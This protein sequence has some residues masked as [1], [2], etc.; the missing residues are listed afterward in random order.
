MNPLTGITEY[1][2]GLEK[3]LRLLAWT[4]GTAIFGAAAL[5]T[6][7]LLVLFIKQ[8]AFSDPSVFW[9]R[10]LLFLAVAAAI[11]AG[12]VVPLLRL[13][14]GRAARRAEQEFPQFQERLLTFTERAKTKADDP[15]L[16]LLA[17]DALN[18]AKTADSDAVAPRSWIVSFASAGVVALA[19]LLWLGMAGPGYLGYGTSLLWAGYA[20]D[21]R[22]PIYSIAVN[23]GNSTIRRRS[24]LRVTAKLTGFEAPKVNVM[25]RYASS[26][27]W[28]EAPMQ[29]RQDAPGYEFF[30]ASVPEPVEYYVEAGGVKSST[31]KINVSDLPGVKHVKVTYHFPSWSGIPDSTEDPGGDLRAVEGT[32]AQ[33]EITTDK[34]LS[35]GSLIVD[36]NN[37][38]ELKSGGGNT[39]VASVPINKDGLYHVAASDNGEM[40]RLSDDYFIEA[41]KD[42]PPTVTINRPGKDAKVNPIE[43]VTITA[44]GKDDFGV[45]ALDLHYSVN[46]GDEKV[47]SLLKNK[48]AKTTEGS[49]TVTL[50]DY[51]LV[52]GDL[53]SFYATAKDARTT[54]KTDIYF[55]QAEPFE[56]NYSQSQQGGG[57]GGGGDGN[58]Q[59]QISQ[60]QKE[61]IAATWNQLKSTNKATAAENAK[62]LSEVQ[63]KLKDQAQS[64]ADRMKARQLAGTN[65]AFTSFVKDMEAAVAAMTP[66]AG[67]LKGQ[68]WNTALPPEQ[69]ALQYLLRAEAT[70]RD[71]QV[72]FGQRGGGGGGGGGASRDLESLF[73]LELDKDKNQY[74]SSQQSQAEQRNKAVDDAMRKLEELARRQQA[75]ADQARNN[76]QTPQQRWQQ[77]MLRREAEQLRQQME[78]LQRDQQGQ[79]SQQSQQGQQGQQSASSSSSQ[80]S[81][82]SQ[83]GQSGQS[84]RMQQQSQLSRGQQGQQQQQQ[85]NQ[86][87]QQDNPVARRDTS[88][89]QAQQLEQALNRLAEAER[90]MAAASSAMQNGRQQQQQQQ[91]GQQGQQQGQQQAGQRGHQNGAQGQ[92]GGQQQGAGSQAQAQADARKAAEQ[93][94]AARDMLSRMREQENGDAMSNIVREAN[95]IAQQQEAFGH[96]MQQQ[97]GAGAPDPFANQGGFR[98]RRGPESV[99]DLPDLGT[100]NQ[101]QKQLADEHE[102]MANDVQ[103]LE[104]Q[105]QGA[106][107]DMMGTNRDAAN[108]LRQ[109]LGNEQQEEVPNKL[110][111]IAGMLNRGLGP[112]AVMREAP[113]TQALNNLRDQVQQVQSALNQGPGKGGKNG[114]D[115]ALEAA[116]Q[117]AEKLRQEIEALRGRQ[118]DPN[119]QQ[120]QQQGRNGQRGQQGQQGQQGQRGG[121]QPGQQ[122]QQGGQQQG[123]QAQGGQQ[124]GGQQQGGQQAGGQQGGQQQGGQQQGGQQE[125]GQQEGGQQMGGQMAGGPRGGN[126]GTRIGG[127]GG[128]FWDPQVARRSYEDAVRDVNRLQNAVRD[129]PDMLR[130]LRDIGNILP[131]LDPN[132]YPGGMGRDLERLFVQA[133]TNI[134]Q[135]EVQLRR[136]V[137]EQNGGAI[138]SATPQPPP[139]GYADAVADYFRRLSKDH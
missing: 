74:E 20:K 25:A 50:E 129:N 17:A 97:F 99:E 94:S 109:A 134:E 126:I 61:I 66:A 77:E 52:P 67:E 125:G 130:Q 101:S 2:A 102:K 9:A 57:G 47:V 112:Y 95:R 65:A 38:I 133:M 132:R 6:T 92:Q 28:E 42:A 51:K 60:R 72:S 90:Q 31:Y 48:G 5:I 124:Q 93:L 58:E 118:G 91:G 104:Q 11:S 84:G 106:V 70:F 19:I 43:E 113:V 87:A 136:K 32:V 39:L 96:K 137:E 15:F 27:K 49:T 69:K 45:M 121:Q 35:N 8:F 135:V 12:L 89:G 3:K 75:L 59:N 117:Q 64:L 103:R 80:S 7:V 56:R 55:I 37:K 114:D 119:G 54:V 128:A 111:G 46:G 108:K 14:R 16:P 76:Q 10:V 34:P 4:R 41:R 123:Q 79:Q 40:V 33:V 1:L 63:G 82:S 100:A 81:Q 30:F 18:V 115:K 68:K 22:K 71:I 21:E 73:D 85:R 36:E 107:R 116:L 138:R 62:Y 26:S 78:Q 131:A 98:R 24:D 110:K 120:G 127:P 53:V 44:T 23:P 105:I 13:N 86:Q 83:S 122:G 29:P 88:R 139:P